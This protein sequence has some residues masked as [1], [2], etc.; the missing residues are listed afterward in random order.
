MPPVIDP[1]KCKR[2]GK[3]VDICT[4]DVFFG[5]EKGELP[6][7]TYPE[8]CSHFNC[9]V[10]ECPEEGAITLRIPLPLMLLYKESGI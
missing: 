10:F 4:E 9:C 7:V 5:S 3:C 2:C 6:T 1:N 8:A